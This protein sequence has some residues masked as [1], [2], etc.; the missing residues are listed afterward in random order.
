MIVSEE[1]NAAITDAPCSV[2]F[3]LDFL[4]KRNLTLKK[5]LITHAHCEHIFALRELAEK[6]GAEVYI[7]E[8]EKDALKDTKKNFIDFMNIL[9]YVPYDGPLHLLKDG[10]TISLDEVEIKVMHVPG[11]SPGSVMYIAGNSIFSGDVLSHNAVGHHNIPYGDRAQMRESL[12]KIKAIKGDYDVYPAHWTTTKL[13]DEQEGNLSE[14]PIVRVS[15][16]IKLGG[17]L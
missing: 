13:R 3:I 9:D 16:T 10:D 2:G 12:E 5:V 17:E 15:A 8:S 1:N 6:T 14:F 7:H 11:H 4:Q